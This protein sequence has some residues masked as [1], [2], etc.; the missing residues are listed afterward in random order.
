MMRLLK[1]YS[2]KCESKMLRGENQSYEISIHPAISFLDNLGGMK[3][4]RRVRIL[5]KKQA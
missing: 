4:T 3:K 1:Q 5:V 2:L